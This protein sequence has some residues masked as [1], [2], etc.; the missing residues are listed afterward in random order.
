MTSEKY[1]EL[2]RESAD[3][4]L[5]V[6]N[7]RFIDCNKAALQMLG[8]KQKSE[9]LGMHPSRISPPSQPDGSDS[10]EKAELMMQ[11]AS[12]NGN[13]R[14]EWDHLRANGEV[15]PVEVLLTAISSQNDEKMFHTVWRDISNRK[16]A[17]SLQDATTQLSYALTTL[18]DMDE[19]GRVAARS[20]RGFFESDAIA[21]NYIDHIAK[22]NRGVYTEDTLEGESEPR[23]FK[24]L[25]SPFDT[26]DPDSM[27]G[28]QNPKLILRTPEKF[29]KSPMERPFGEVDRKSASLMF[30]PIVWD[31]TKVG[32][33]TVQSYT[34]NKYSEESLKQLQMFANLIG[35]A[36]LRAVTSEK[37]V[38]KNEELLRNQARL[39]ISQRLAHV[40]SWE[41][42]PVND[43]SYWSE[44]LY[45]IFQKDPGKPVNLEQLIESIHPEDVEL[46]KK[47]VKS[48]V[49]VRTD[50]RIILPNG[51]IR[52]IHEELGEPELQDGQPVWLHGSIQDITE[53]KRNLEKLRESET[54]FR[55]LA[56]HTQDWEYLRKPDGTFL[57]IS[58]S[59]EQLTGYSVEEHTQNPELILDILHEDSREKMVSHWTKDNHKDEPL[60]TT[61]FQIRHKD[62]ATKWLEHHCSPVFDSKGNFLGRRGNNRDITDRKRAEFALSHY[63]HIVSSTT[64]M[65]AFV[66]SNYTYLAANKAYVKAINMTIEEIVGKTIADVFGKPF[67]ES[68][69]KPNA[70]KCLAGEAIHYQ[71]WANYPAYGRRFV[72][73]SYNSYY[74]SDQRIL[75]L[76]ITTRDIT[77][78][79]LAE[80][81]KADLEAQLRQSQ[82]LEAVGRMAG[83]IAHEFNNI[84]QGF[85]LYAG[86]IKKQLPEEGELRSLF[87]NILEVGDRARDLVGQILTFSRK[88]ETEFRPTQI[89][90]LV[91]D[92]LKLIR[93]SATV[94]IEVIADFT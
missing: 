26:L 56:E 4:I 33:V 68:V 91:K 92:A 20:L 80:D 52:F 75:G 83:G 70:D 23:E 61:E 78:M 15:F 54:R 79:K 27:E 84:L 1:T 22:I 58:P 44:E 16:K 45:R 12:E 8:Y 36:F 59:C 57:Y 25:S 24:P 76:V 7:G 10:A 55:L 86:I 89:Q 85:Y 90:Y 49:P 3:A 40:G 43:V 60:F 71:T 66:D 9:I 93:A 81:G 50:Y 62:G 47:E 38:Q 21:I 2:F 67:F 29:L 65:L 42:D 17:Q 37:L 94:G 77:E 69:I 41:Y 82:K 5:L 32:E 88:E 46:F 14:F 87:Q 30:A 19:I 74:D 31:G 13:H 35:G 63:Q 18:M 39:K 6:R 34:F 73:S 64:D 48:H 51:D 11:M 53:Q 72:D 28:S